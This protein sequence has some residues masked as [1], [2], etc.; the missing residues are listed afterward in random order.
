MPDSKRTITV[1][2]AGF[3]GTVIATVYARY[4]YRVLMTDIAPKA[5]ETFRERAR[6]IAESLVDDQIG[7]NAILDGVEVEP[8][9]EAAMKDAFFVHEAIHEN[10]EAK[11][12]LFAKLDQ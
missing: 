4:N 5:L 9:F 12:D 8:N 10:L 3:M 1:V 7:L 2:G 6:P 11:Q